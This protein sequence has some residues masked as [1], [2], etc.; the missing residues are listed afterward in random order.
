MADSYWQSVGTSEPY[1]IS[2]MPN[3]SEATERN[4]ANQFFQQ[5]G[6]NE[7]IAMRG[8]SVCLR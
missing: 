1:A 6:E 5:T 2:L 3:W 7:L 4:E 8:P